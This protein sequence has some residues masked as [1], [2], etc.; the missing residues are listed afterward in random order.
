VFD[1]PRELVWRAWADPEHFQRWWGP[2]GFTAP[3]CRMD[4]R[5]GGTYL[6]CM[7]A[8]D[9]ME[10][11]TAGV[12]REIVHL[13]RIVYTDSFADAHGNRVPSSHYGLSEALPAELVVTVA[14]EEVASGTRLTVR[15][16]SMP[17]AGEHG[18]M[19]RE[20]WIQSLDKLA[21]SLG[22]AAAAA[23]EEAVVDADRELVL[24]RVYDAPRERVFDAWTD[25]KGL[26]TWWGPDGFRT[27]TREFDLRPGG[28]WRFVMHAPDGTDFENRIDFVQILRP[29]RLLYRHSG[30]GA[31]A[32]VRFYND[33]TFEALGAKT[34]LT[35]RSVFDSAAVLKMVVEKY[36]AIEG[37]R[38]HLERLAAHLA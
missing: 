1:A 3:A 21:E 29:Q 14:F 26:E 36:G 37:G 17:A 28:V 18:E 9:G 11:W 2:K 35:M 32:D 10:Y 12:F 4:F 33:I 31:T 34:R 27:T 16:A 7:R 25:L 20:G 38:Q 15:H 22:A 24:S 8:P 13:Q 23:P 30:E 6:W 19:A 5:V